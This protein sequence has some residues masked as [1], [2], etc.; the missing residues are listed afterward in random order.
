M[1]CEMVGVGGDGRE[2]M[3]AR[4]SIVNQYGQCIY[5]KFVQPQEEVTD[6]RTH[7]S[8]IRPAD[9]VKGRSFSQTL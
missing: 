5:D 1:D 9:L 4:V 2:S 8:G 7:V 6:Y 3:L